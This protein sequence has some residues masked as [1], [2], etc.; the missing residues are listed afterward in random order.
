VQSIFDPVVAN[1]PT[2]VDEYSV[3][4]NL[5]PGVDPQSVLLQLATDMD[6]FLGGEL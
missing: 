1:K 6:Q 5:P 4:I 2:T 3:H